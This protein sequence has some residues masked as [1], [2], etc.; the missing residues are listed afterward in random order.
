MERS[1]LE[2]DLNN[3]RHNYEIIKK[4]V[5]NKEIL[6]IVKADGYGCGISEISK[7]LFEIGVKN[8]GVSSL[9]EALE[10]KKVGIE[11]NILILEIIGH[12]DYE[13]AFE[14]N[15]QIAISS[16]E[17]I[18]YIEENNFK[19][20]QIHIKIDLNFE[21]KNF[22]NDDILKWME[23]REKFKKIDVIGIFSHF[24]YSEKIND[25]NYLKI[26]IQNFEIYEKIKGIKYLHIKNS[27]GI[28]KYNELCNSN[29]VRPGIMLYGY[30]NLNQEIR[31]ISSLK[32]KIVHL[33]TI[34]KD[35][36]ISYGKEGFLKSGQMVATISIGYGDGYP[37]R[38]SN[39][40]IMN[41]AGIEC[42]VLG[43]ICMD[44]TMI[45]IPE[46]LKK[47]VCV[48]TIVDVMGGNMYEQ[49]EKANISPYEFLVGITKRVERK[50]INLN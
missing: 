10:L 43:R 4:I 11:N 34:E 40:G 49:F 39:I 6:A 18:V 13:K 36:Y 1:W 17:D 48:G 37:R 47:K 24:S 7:T 15:F 5:I 20:P 12:D 46:I 28:I 26:Q 27:V 33:K 42:K 14:N 30:T 19:N 32:S 22:L 35:S 8:F 16:Y 50:Y 3:L 45:E 41:I 23:N 21:K 44:T 2:I 25:E 29:M 31:K 9:E 38:F